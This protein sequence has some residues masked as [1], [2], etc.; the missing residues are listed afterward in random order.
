MSEET[1]STISVSAYE[2]TPRQHIFDQTWW[3]VRNNLPALGLFLILILCVISVILYRP[4][5]STKPES[6]GLGL[7]NVTSRLLT[8]P[9]S[10]TVSS[11]YV[12][13][14]DDDL[15]ICETVTETYSCDNL[16]QSPAVEEVQPVLHK[17]S[18][19]IAYY[20]LSDSVIHLYTLELKSRTTSLVTLRSGETGLHTEYKILPTLAP[21]FSPNGQWV[22][23]SAQSTKNN[24]VELFAAR[25]DGQQVLRLTDLSYQVLD[26]TWLNDDTIL[27]VAQRPNGELGY[28]KA[29]LPPGKSKPDD[30]KKVNR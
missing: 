11:Q 16:T 20:G 13:L 2:P 30:L 29:Y 4:I 19:Q 26:Y 1:K 22:A 27:V 3:G 28:W 8:L 10:S 15:Y 12:M 6:D 24:V 18:E 7:P 25:A 14:E 5:L 17:D 9:Y 23:F 21:V